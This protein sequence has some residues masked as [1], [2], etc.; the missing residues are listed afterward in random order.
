MSAPPRCQDLPGSRDL[1]S[2]MILAFTLIILTLMSMMG[3]TILLNS[4]TE[5]NISSNTSQ[6]RNAFA[7]A[8]TAARVATLIGRILLHPELSGDLESYILNSTIGDSG[9]VP[10]DFQLHVEVSDELKNEG[11]RA[12]VDSTH[13]FTQRYIRAGSGLEPHVVFTRVSDNVPVAT[14]ALS[15]DH[16]A[17]I[18]PGMSLG[19]GDAYDGGGGPSLSVV[20]VV[21]VNGRAMGPRLAGSGTFEGGTDDEARSIITILYREVI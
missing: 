1:R 20:L 14:A 8:D 17:P 10:G 15:V 9:K 16:Q 4:R 13:D 5:L 19:G 7:S 3:V 18:T 21:S 11:L 2:G 12:D 6:G